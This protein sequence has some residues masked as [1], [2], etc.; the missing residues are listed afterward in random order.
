[1]EWA[2]PPMTELGVVV[3]A[4][5]ETTTEPDSGS[6][7]T[8]RQDGAKYAELALCLP[9]VSYMALLALPS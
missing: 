1:M 8:I 3:E 7:L 2:E 5:R 6:T 9:L 4:G